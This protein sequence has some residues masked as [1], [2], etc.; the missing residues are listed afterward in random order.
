[1][2]VD[3]VILGEMGDLPFTQSGAALL[4]HLLSKRYE[5]T[6]IV[7][8]THFSFAE[9]ANVFGDAKM[10]IALLDQLTHNP[11]VVGSSPTGPTIK[12]STY[13]KQPDHACAEF[14][15]RSL[16]TTS[17]RLARCAGEGWAYRLTISALSQAPIS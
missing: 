14:V 17:A 4:F 1:M 3:L 11:L 2:Y 5:R 8:T 12:S 9:W 6:S 13:E 16:S 10:T 15:L 7:I